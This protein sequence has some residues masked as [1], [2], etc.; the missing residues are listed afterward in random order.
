MA[1][2]QGQANIPSTAL[3]AASSLTVARVK[4]AANQRV[5][6]QGY[7][8]YFDGTSNSAVPVQ[9]R[10]GRIATDITSPSSL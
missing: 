3:P 1:A 5:R 9:I 8:F 7:G 10:I 4:A 2:L 6:V